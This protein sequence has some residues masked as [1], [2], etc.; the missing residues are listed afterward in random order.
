MAF[1]HHGD[2]AIYY[3]TFGR[4]SD[5]PLL[6]ISG[7]GSQCI[8]YREEMCERLAAGRYFV[9]RFDN[10]DVGL[11]S[12]MDDR[13]EIAGEEK[14]L[15]AG[16]TSGRASY[17]LGDMARDALAVLDALGIERAHV[18]GASM[19]GMI[20][21]TMAIEHA[22]RLLTLTSFMSTTGDPDVGRSSPKAHQLFTSPRAKDRDSYVALQIAGARI[23]GSP[24]CLD[25]E[26]RAAIAAEAFDRNFCPAGVGRQLLAIQH[27]GSRTAALAAVRVPTLVLHGDADQLID[28]SGGRR[29]AEAIPGA[30]FV[31][32]EGLGHDYL[33]HYW[34]QLIGLVHAHVGEIRE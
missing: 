31:L 29:T 6:L 33:P 22:E 18:L 13:S 19:G 34:D 21:Q 28:A 9:I 26:Y 10:R 15:N 27:S 1:A 11:S 7:L 23:W 3:D 30:R 20:A 32:I 2:V 4:P 14:R 25:V 5:S 12:K 16:A 17:L 8:N 24:A